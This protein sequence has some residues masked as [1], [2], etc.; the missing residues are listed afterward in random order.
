MCWSCSVD[1]P[2]I[3]IPVC[4]LRKHGLEEEFDDFLARALADGGV[5]F[6]GWDFR[7]NYKQLVPSFAA[8]FGRRA[9][10]VLRYDTVDSVAPL[11]DAWE[12]CLHCRFPRSPIG[13]ASTNGSLW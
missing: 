4:Q 5:V 11:L 1:R 13:S 8:V 9:V 6:R 10:H 2:N 3:S 7:V 12:G